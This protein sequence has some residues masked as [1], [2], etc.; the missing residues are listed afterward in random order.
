MDKPKDIT[1]MSV[2]ELKA[3]AYDLLAQQQQLQN[4]LGAINEQIS[5]K[6]DKPEVVKEKK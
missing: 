3:L 4:S 1:K 6:L 2:T 5:K